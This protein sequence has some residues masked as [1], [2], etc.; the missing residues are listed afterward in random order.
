MREY[1]ENANK[2]ED[3]ADA[4]KELRV[5]FHKEIFNECFNSRTFSFVILFT[6]RQ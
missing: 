5:L 3:V 2:Q 4:A 6:D 1:A